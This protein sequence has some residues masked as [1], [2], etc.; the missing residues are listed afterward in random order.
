MAYVLTEEDKSNVFTV[1][2]ILGYASGWEDIHNPYLILQ[3]LTTNSYVNEHRDG[4]DNG[5]LAFYGDRVIEWYVTRKL[6][7]RFSFE[8]KEMPWLV[9]RFHKKEY[10]DTK[11][12]LVCRKNLA[13]IASSYHLENYIRTGKGSANTEKDSTNVLGEL[14]EAL[15][16]AFAIDSSYGIHDS[17]NSNSPW[18]NL[19]TSI[20][21]L[22]GSPTQIN[23]NR[24]P[25]L[26]T[27]DYER[28]DKV[29]GGFL[30]IEHFLDKEAL[31][32]SLNGFY[33]Y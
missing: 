26:M 30:D 29:I 28:I 15:A 27:M 6:M 17:Q 21:S 13:R 8:G 18:Y 24:L 3:A 25:D 31:E 5:V 23:Q 32:G 12:K 33:Y 16:G 2:R 10:T 20:A 22:C 14:R 9:S 1:S 7:D 11:S 19:P 4:L